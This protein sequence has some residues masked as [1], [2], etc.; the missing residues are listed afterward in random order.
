VVMF[1]TRKKVLRMP[2]SLQA[3]PGKMFRKILFARFAALA[4]I[5]FLL[6]KFFCFEQAALLQP[7]FPK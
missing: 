6:N 7:V 4:R 1:M 3:L 5:S 2:E